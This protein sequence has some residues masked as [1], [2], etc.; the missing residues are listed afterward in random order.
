M[1]KME[2]QSEIDNVTMELRSLMDSV[3]DTSKDVNL[4]EVRTKK[5]ELEEKRANLIKQMAELDKPLA[6]GS[7]EKTVWRQMAEAMIEKRTVNLAGTGV[8][9]TLKELVKKVV[10]KTD[11]LDGVRFFYGKDAATKIPVWGTQLKADFVAEGTTGTAKTNVAGVTTID[12]Q[13]ILSSLP[14]SQM[15]LDLGAANLEAEL[16]GL[17]E[18]A[19][20]DLLA[21]GMCNGKV[22]TVG[23]ETVVA[24]VGVFTASNTSVFNQACT[25]VKLGEFARGLRSKKYRNPEII[26]SNAV[27]TKFLGDTSTDETTKIYKE[28]LIRDKKIEDVVVKLTDYAPSTGSGSSG[29]WADN[30]VICV[31]MDASNYAIGMAGQLN[32]TKKDVP[33]STVVYFDANAYAGGKPVLA[34]DVHQYKIDIA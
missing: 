10:S 24:M 18:E 23:E 11:V 33:S 27:Y 17:F 21:D 4:D 25:M 30:D 15:M 22:I 19:I 3:K 7:E 6:K 29:A 20:A 16:P 26:M 34:A 1:N 14:V 32:I 5:A 28:G 13:E 2:F 9:N 8:V 31:G 12:A